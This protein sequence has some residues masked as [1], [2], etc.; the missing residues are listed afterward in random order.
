MNI[1]GNN[2]TH[3]VSG[4]STIK[5]W[6]FAQTK[7]GHHPRLFNYSS[8]CQWLFPN[9]LFIIDNFFKKYIKIK[10]TCSTL[11]I[12][13]H[14]HQMINWFW[15]I[16]FNKWNIFKYPL[17]SF[18][19]FFD[20]KEIILENIKIS[21]NNIISVELAK[22]LGYFKLDVWKWIVFTIMF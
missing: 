11:A 16:H 19:I 7:S 2:L 8:M 9:L 13:T 20:F 21:E 15:N 17:F 1:Q 18:T 14:V 5:L 22:V 10:K 4:V 12:S 3:Y 6:C